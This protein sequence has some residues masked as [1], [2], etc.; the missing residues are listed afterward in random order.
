M[1]VFEPTPGRRAAGLDTWYPGELAGSHI[2]EPLNVDRVDNPT[3]DYRPPVSSVGAEPTLGALTG[4]FAHGSGF[5]QVEP[6]AVDN[7][8]DNSSSS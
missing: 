8:G 7:G 1:R 2:A 5:G 6:K 3:A 4:T